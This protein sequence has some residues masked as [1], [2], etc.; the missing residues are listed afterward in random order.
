MLPIQAMVMDI[1]IS[2]GCF[3]G[4]R[5]F[6]SVPIVRSRRFLNINFIDYS[7]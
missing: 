6:N 2:V 7:L 5:L 1:F 4:A 3:N